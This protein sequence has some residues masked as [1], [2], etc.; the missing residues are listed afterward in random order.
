MYPPCQQV[1]GVLL[2]VVCIFSLDLASTPGEHALEVAHHNNER[3]FQGSNN[4][5][6][7]KGN[8]AHTPT[9]YSSQP[10]PGKQRNGKRERRHDPAEEVPQQTS[11]TENILKEEDKIFIS[12]TTLKPPTDQMGIL[13]YCHATAY[14]RNYG[15]N[16][17]LQARPFVTYDTVAVALRHSK[18]TFDPA[19]WQKG[20]DQEG[21]LPFKRSQGIVA[22]YSGIR[23]K[24]TARLPWAR[25]QM[26]NFLN[27]LRK[28]FGRENIT[29]LLQQHNTQGPIE[30]WW[31]AAFQNISANVIEFKRKDIGGLLHPEFSGIQNCG[32]KIVEVEESRG[33]PF[34]YAVRMRYDLIYDVGNQNL[35]YWPIWD[36]TSVGPV[37]AFTEYREDHPLINAH[38]G[39]E[40]VLYRP[41]RC[42][43]QDIFFIARYSPKLSKSSA[44]QFFGDHRTVHRYPG[45]GYNGDELPA[46]LY[47]SLFEGGIPFHLVYQIDTCMW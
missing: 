23:K 30:G 4:N 15:L 11:P 17:T 22:C 21:A 34:R 27:P 37:L 19:H 35:R 26:R 3:G 31:K 12:N 43:A 44:Y 8:S 2:V 25:T 38:I 5:G 16:S 18:G 29:I 45:D 9:S 10:A 24:N 41:V 14:V 39:D 40:K 6:N 28:M 13:N 7:W 46:A 47:W 42:E 36:P 1:L 32:H 33:F 20:E